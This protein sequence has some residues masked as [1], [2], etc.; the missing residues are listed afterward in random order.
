MSL[1][2]GLLDQLKTRGLTVS[3]QEGDTLL[4]GGPAE[5]KTPQVMAALKVFKPELLKR[6]R[7]NGPQYHEVH[8]EAPEPEEVPANQTTCTQCKAFVWDGEETAVLCDQKTC[9]Y[10]RA[11]RGR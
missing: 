4:L 5:E 2:Q 6:L 9:P 3:W 10:K 7:P 11:S 8:H 1:V